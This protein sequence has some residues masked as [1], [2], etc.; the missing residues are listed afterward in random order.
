MES[1]GQLAAGIAHE[2]NTPTQF[3]GDNLCFLK[4][5]FDGL[6]EMFAC[7]DADRS[8][9]TDAAPT[10]KL[11]EAL[12]SAADA[13]DLA[14][15]RVEIPKAIAQSL[16]GV[17]R[18]AAITKAMKEFSHP[19]AV[20]MSSVNL[21]HAIENTLIVCTNE[22]KYVAEI[23]TEFD[24]A[25]S[26]ID[27]LPGELNQ[28]I[29]NLIVNAAQAI[30]EVSDGY[31]D[32]KGQI[33]IRTRKLDDWAEISVTDNGPGIPE[34]IRQRVFD[35]FFTTKEVGKGTGQGLAIAHAVIVE[36]HQGTI[37]LQS[38]VGVGTSLVLRLPILA[39]HTDEEH[40]RH[41]E[42]HFV[43]GR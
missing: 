39:P 37:Q 13:A 9:L 32:G 35:P 10:R 33:T 12:V 40:A 4:D 2:I 19:G 17:Q 43:C 15:L 26:T 41:E 25:L 29:L 18:I 38:E 3:A 42:T 34:A 27:C 23:A 11:W 22:W 21:H 5:A 14:Y 28:V 7:L 24:P 36:K 30:G 6:D 1:V 20:S 16:E 31:P 8:R